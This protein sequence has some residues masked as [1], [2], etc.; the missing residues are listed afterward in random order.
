MA[1]RPK[2]FENVHHVDILIQVNPRGS[3][4]YGWVRFFARTQYATDRY[5]DD[6]TFEVAYQRNV[7]NADEKRVYESHIPD[8]RFD[9]GEHAQ[10]AFYAGHV[11]TRICVD[12]PEQAK[13][14]HDTVKALSKATAKLVNK[15]NCDLACMVDAI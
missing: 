10:G 9:I 2:V 5:S 7:V 15:P 4:S 11:E 8:H 6:L 13:H 12:Y 14:V 1:K 3:Y